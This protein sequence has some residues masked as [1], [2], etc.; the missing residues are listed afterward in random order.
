MGMRRYGFHSEPEEL[1]EQNL[2]SMEKT[3]VGGDGRKWKI[4]LRADA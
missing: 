1:E 2:C 4:S 3:Q